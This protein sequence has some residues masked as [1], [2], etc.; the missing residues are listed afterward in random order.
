MYAIRSY[1]ADALT[2]QSINKCGS[3]LARQER[4]LRIIFKVPATERSTLHVDPWP[5]EQINLHLAS[6]YPQSYTEF[7]Q[8][9]R[10][11]GRTDC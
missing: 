1:Y 6:F 11:P 2:L 10:V 9:V 3:K 7:L 8:E 5:Q 4:I